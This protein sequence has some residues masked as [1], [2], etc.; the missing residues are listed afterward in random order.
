MPNSAN[1]SSF[2]PLSPVFLLI[3]ASAAPTISYEPDI[4]QIIFITTIA[5][6]N[7]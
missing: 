7:K 3:N 6:T 2:L 4:H 1:S 5:T